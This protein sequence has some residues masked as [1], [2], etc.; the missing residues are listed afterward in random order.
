MGSR[1][2]EGMNLNHIRAIMM[3][4]LNAS[5]EPFH[6][7][8]LNLPKTSGLNPPRTSRL[9]SPR[10]SGL[11]PP[12]TGRLK[13]PRTSRLNPHRTSTLPGLVG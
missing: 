7:G 10:T 2:L 4:L 13:P 6:A 5:S 1:G 9:I 11:N 8:G 3:F 12:R